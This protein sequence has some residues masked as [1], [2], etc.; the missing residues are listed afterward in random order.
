M[1]PA[2]LVLSHPNN[3][4]REVIVKD[5]GSFIKQFNFP[6]YLFTNFPTSKLTEFEYNGSFFHNYNPQISSGTNWHVWNLIPHTHLK[7]IKHISNWSYSGTHC[8]HLGFKFLKMMGYTH[9]FFFGYDSE[10][11]YPK[12]KKYIDFSLNLF[13]QGKTGIFQE[14]PNLNGHEGICTTTFACEVDFFIN[15][16]SELLNQYGPHHPIIKENPQYLLEHLFEWTLRPYKDNINIIPLADAIKDTYKSADNKPLPDGSKYF[17][18]YYKALEKVLITTS[19]L[20]PEKIKIKDESGKILNLELLS[21][22]DSTQIFQ[23]SPILNSILYIEFDNCP[24]STISY[25][26]DWKSNVYF[27]EQ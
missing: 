16:F 10:M 20:T 21:I 13:N 1:K 4:E 12:M 18:G 17:I 2:V 15:T 19:S 23:I 27:I 22:Y 5:F 14:Y 3:N 9:V 7:H 24:I 8:A 6:A 11:D 25:N 26:E